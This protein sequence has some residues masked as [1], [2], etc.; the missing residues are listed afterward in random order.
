M[1]LRSLL[2]DEVSYRCGYWGDAA[3]RRHICD[4]FLLHFIFFLFH[5]RFHDGSFIWLSH[6]GPSH[7]DG[8]GVMEPLWGKISAHVDTDLQL[9][10]ATRS[11]HFFH[12]VSNI[13]PNSF[14]TTF[15]HFS[16]P[17]NQVRPLINSSCGCNSDTA[18]HF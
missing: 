9:C 18:P 10:L 15:V 5:T 13:L 14:R 17:T 4:S 11:L 12:Q 6:G 1:F 7:P 3:T 2:T 8:M 16:E